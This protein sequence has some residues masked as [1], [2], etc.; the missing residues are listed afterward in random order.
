MKLI[1]TIIKSYSS[2]SFY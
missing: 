1:P 2:T